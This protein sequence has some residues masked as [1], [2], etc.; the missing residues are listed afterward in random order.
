MKKTF[1]VDNPALLN[2]SLFLK[3]VE[4]ILGNKMDGP[5]T[6][7]LEYLFC[8]TYGC[9]FALAVNSASS[10]FDI[11]LAFLKTKIPFGQICV[12]TIGNLDAIHSIK[13]ANFDPVF[14]DVDDNYCIDVDSLEQR[15]GVHTAAV[16]PCN[17]FGNLA[18]LEAISKFNGLFTL[19]DSSNAL[20]GYDDSLDTCV[21]NFGDCE[22]ISFDRSTILPGFDGAILSTNDPELYQFALAY[23]LSGYDSLLK[24]IMVGTSCRMSEIHAAAILCQLENTE[25]V[26]SHSFNI[27]QSYKATMPEWVHFCEPNMYFSN[28]GQIVIRVRPEIRDRLIDHLTTVGVYAKDIL[29]AHKLRGYKEHNHHVLPNAERLCDETILLPSGLGID[30]EDIVIITNA[31][32]EFAQ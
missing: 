12:P 8:Q 22:V 20:G 7:E 27:W 24:S 23:S 17:L 15:L 9:K 16:M 13:R 28:F 25:E 21:G 1:E 29:P 31:I 19:V 10:A 26:Q 5:Y 4:D 11:A 3:R 18:D 32:K 30:E 2:K 6:G 14:V